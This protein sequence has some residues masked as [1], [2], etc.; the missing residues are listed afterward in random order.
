MKRK[1]IEKEAIESA[2]DA[3]KGKLKVAAERLGVS[4]CTL[5]ADLRHHHIHLPLSTVTSKRLGAKRI[6]AIREALGMG[7]Q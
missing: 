3:A 5:A 6:A 4:F 1:R 7:S 2:L